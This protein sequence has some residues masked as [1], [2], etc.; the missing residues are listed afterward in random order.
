MTRERT[1]EAVLAL[2][3]RAGEILRIGLPEGEITTFSTDAGPTP[4]GI[5]VHRDTVLG[6]VV[7]WTT[8]GAPLVV[9]EGEANRLYHRRDGGVHAMAGGVRRQVVEPGHVTTGKQ[10]AL[11]PDGVLYWGD[12]EGTRV[13]RV[14]VDGSGLADLVV[15]A[16]DDVSDW[17]IGVAVDPVRG[18]LYWSQKGPVKGGQG[19]IFRAGLE[20]PAGETAEERTDIELL[21]SGLPEPIDLHLEGDLLYW[22]DRGEPPAGNTL[23]RAPLPASGEPGAAPEIL[24]GGFSEAIGLVVDAAA[25]L[26][27]V[28]DLGGHLWEVAL[29]GSGAPPRLVCKHTGPITGLAAV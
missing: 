2:T 3:V 15:N 9:G 12:R 7:Y 16:G 18:H 20:I 28:S 21:W 1:V 6:D 17:C 13:S 19:R 14:A 11:D 23:N 26:A 8:M 24:G 27:Y 25:G 10:I 4:D 5:V 29:T 22:T